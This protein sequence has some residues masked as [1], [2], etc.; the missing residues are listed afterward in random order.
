MMKHNGLIPVAC[1]SPADQPDQEG[2]LH[3]Q[4]LSA[5]QPHHPDEAR[6][7]ANSQTSQTTQPSYVQE[8]SVQTPD[9][10]ATHGN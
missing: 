10:S 9:H 7:Y 5:Q 3:F 4:N 8:Q 1:F 6:F 2:F